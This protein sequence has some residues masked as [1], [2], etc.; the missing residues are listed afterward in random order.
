MKYQNP[1]NRRR[2]ER[3]LNA[4]FIRWAQRTF[5]WISNPETTAFASR[6][7]QGRLESR[8]K[9]KWCSHCQCKSLATSGVWQ[10][11]GRA[12][13][14]NCTLSLQASP[15][16][17][18]HATAPCIPVSH[19][20]Q[21]QQGS[22]WARRF[23]WLEIRQHRSATPRGRRSRRLRLVSFGRAVPAPG[24]PKK[25]GSDD[26]GSCCRCDADPPGQR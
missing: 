19:A 15:Q 18:G 14:S 4:S 5:S 26:A 20:S 11:R 17:L 9:M 25:P 10:G 22:S 23:W 13:G 8:T 7:A 16:S 2:S 3:S 6:N 21:L 24:K 12:L 1:R